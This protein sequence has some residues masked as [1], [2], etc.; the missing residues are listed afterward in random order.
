MDDISSAPQIE[1]QRLAHSELD[2]YFDEF[3]SLKKSEDWNRII[4]LGEVA[5][6]EAVRKQRWVDEA[7]IHAQLASTEYYKGNYLKTVEHADRCRALAHCTADEKLLVRSMYLQSAAYRALAGQ[8]KGDD[9]DFLFSRAAISGQDALKAYHDRKISDD[10]LLGKVYFNLGA[11][12]S[13][14]PKGN[15]EQ[16]SKHY[17]DA[18]TSFRQAQS[19]DDIVRATVRLAKVRLLQDQPKEAEK[20]VTEVR[21][22]VRAERDLM[23][24]EYLRA[25]I[26]QSQGS[27]KEAVFLAGQALSRAKKLGAQADEQRFQHFIDSTQK[28]L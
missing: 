15:L 1:E 28:S 9:Q 7:T 16:A 12:E 13:D 25:Q 21:P 23:H 17:I 26:A 2:T 6:Q 20:L 3:T 22:Q 10:N 4:A 5:I 27:S 14:N 18:L 24:L 11:A 8:A 19:S